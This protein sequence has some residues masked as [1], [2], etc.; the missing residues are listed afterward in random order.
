[1]ADEDHDDPAMFCSREI[2][3]AARTVMGGATVAAQ[4]KSAEQ[5]AQ[6]KAATERA[7]AETHARRAAQAAERQAQADR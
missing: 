5:T 1:M 7:Q 4:R 6:A 2:G 3:R